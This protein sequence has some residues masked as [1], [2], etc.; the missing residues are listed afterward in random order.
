[1]RVEF[2]IP[3]GGLHL[4]DRVKVGVA[5]H[6]GVGNVTGF[7]GADRVMVVADLEDPL[8]LAAVDGE[9]VELKVSSAVI[10]AEAPTPSGG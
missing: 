4:G 1:M 8:A 3:R 2:I 10:T 7:V 9:T 5:W 6:H